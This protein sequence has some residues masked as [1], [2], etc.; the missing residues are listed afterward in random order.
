MRLLPPSVLFHLGRHRR[1]P[2]ELGDAVAQLGGP[3]ELEVRRRRELQVAYN[4]EH[5]ITPQSVRSAIDRGIEG[6][7]E[8]HKLTL[9]VA[10]KSGEDYVTEEF[11]EELDGEMLAAAANLEFERAAELRDRIAQLRGQ[12]TLAP[13]V[14]KPRRRRRS[15]Q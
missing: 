9:E 2:L 10:G 4:A 15:A 1:L 8:A 12:P 5:G 3:L 6:E 13:Q 11:L 7:I 14:K